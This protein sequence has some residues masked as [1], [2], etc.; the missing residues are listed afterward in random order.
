LKVA[1]AL[2]TGPLKEAV[3]HAIADIEADKA[4]EARGVLEEALPAAQ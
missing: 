1:F 4:D 2:A 3:E